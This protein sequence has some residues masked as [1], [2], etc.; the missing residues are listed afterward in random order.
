MASL[1]RESSD[2]FFTEAWDWGCLWWLENPGGAAQ[3]KK[4][5]QP[6]G[7]KEGS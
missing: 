3:R 1:V 7:A 6:S 4:R 2:S 5:C